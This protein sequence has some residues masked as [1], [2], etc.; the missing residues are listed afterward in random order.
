MDTPHQIL[1]DPTANIV[2]NRP[3]SKHI[4]GSPA[5]RFWAKVDKN[6]PVPTNAPELGA[7][8]VWTGCAPVVNGRPRPTLS[9]NDRTV[10]AYRFSYE[11]NCG[12]VPC[13]CY[14]YRGC[15]NPLCVNPA[16]LSPK[17]PQETAT[18]RAKTGHLGA[19][20]RKLSDYEVR[21][22]RNL[23]ELG[24]TQVSIA[25]RFN[26]SRTTVYYIHLRKKWKHLV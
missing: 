3:H 12:P 5:E 18:T 26:V 9:V 1:E 7:C 19:Y 10:S 16:H 23:C 25:A 11:L 15:N 4:F 13:G 2:S 21:A 22:I 8:W 17:T 24:E 6:G 20:V 14:L